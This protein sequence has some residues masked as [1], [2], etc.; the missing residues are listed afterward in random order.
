MEPIGLSRVCHGNHPFKI[1][2]HTNDFQARFL[3]GT[4]GGNKQILKTH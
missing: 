4:I 3:G 1:V 2:N